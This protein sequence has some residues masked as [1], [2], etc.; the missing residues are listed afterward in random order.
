MSR[1][2]SCPPG[3]RWQRTDGCAAAVSWASPP[4]LSLVRRGGPLYKVSC[5]AS[6]LALKRR[7]PGPMA[8]TSIAAPCF[9]PRQTGQDSLASICLR[10]ETLTS[11]P[12]ERRRRRRIVKFG[13]TSPAAPPTLPTSIVWRPQTWVK[14]RGILRGH[15]ASGNAPTRPNAAVKVASPFQLSFE[16]T[17]FPLEKRRPWN[18]RGRCDA[19]RRERRADGPHQ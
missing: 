10:T 5:L 11:R 9:R 4:Q 19:E 3:R 16:A 14:D 13:D 8:R 12:A 17:A 15:T 6:C 2:A 1:N 7:R 18:Q